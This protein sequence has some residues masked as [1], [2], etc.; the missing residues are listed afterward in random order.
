MLLFDGPQPALL[1]VMPGWRPRSRS[2]KR[3]QLSPPVR[4]ESEAAIK[5]FWQA[6]APRIEQR[7]AD[8]DSF[9]VTGTSPPKPTYRTIGELADL[10]Q[11]DMSVGVRLSSARTYACQWS[12]VLRR[13]PSTTPL[14]QIGRDKLQDLVRSMISD[15]L[16]PVSIRNLMLVVNRALER[17]IEDEVLTS[18]PLTKVRLPKGKPQPKVAMTVE[19][20]DQL[21]DVAEHHGRD[22]HLLVA[23]GSLAGLRRGEALAIKWSDVNQRTRVLHVRCG[24]GFVTKS[25]RDRVV[26]ICTALFAV[27]TKYRRASGYLVKPDHSSGGAQ[28]WAF[29]KS[30]ERAAREAGVPHITPHGLRHSF[31]TLAA[32]AG[33]S[34][35]LLK[36]WMGH[37]AISTTAD[38]VHMADGY[39]AEIERLTMQPASVPK[40]SRRRQLVPA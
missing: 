12:A 11:A 9:S 23:L 24:D 8:P 34:P 13:L 21:L 36:S 22:L 19:E 32:A 15:G 14:A 39:S 33:V 37:T 31:A 40:R 1:Q 5:L 30:F 3:T 10:V 6:M 29:R 7:L 27:L 26:P 25:G 16:S 17:A 28:R 20:R 38:Y 4:I 35:W 2:S 18:N